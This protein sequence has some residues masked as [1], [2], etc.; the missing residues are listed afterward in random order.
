M[1]EKASKGRFPTP[2]KLES[3]ELKRKGDKER[4]MR[5]SGGEKKKAMIALFVFIIASLLDAKGP[6]SNN[7]IDIL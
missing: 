4:P 7:V 1:K 2:E 6:F 3:K 5:K